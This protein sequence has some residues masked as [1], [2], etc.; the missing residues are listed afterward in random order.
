MVEPPKSY[1]ER[2]FLLM[3]FFFGLTLGI[4]IALGVTLMYVREAGLGKQAKQTAEVLKLIKENYVEEVNLDS[5][6]K[7][8]LQNLLSQLDPHSS[9]IPAEEV[10]LAQSQLETDFEGIGIEYEWLNDTLFVNYPLP[11]SPAE[12]AGIRAGDKILAIDNEPVTY[13]NGENVV[14][15]FQ[16]L[17]GKRGTRVKLKILRNWQILEKSVERDKIVSKSVEGYLADSKI[18]YIRI[19]RF[20]E[21]TDQE[22]SEILESFVQK[23][24]IQALIIDLRENGGGYMDRANRIADELL[25][26]GLLIVSTK[27][28]QK[29]YHQEYKAT[30]GGIFEKG[31]VCVL[32][33][34]G[35]ASASEILAGALQDN[36]RAT[37]IGRKSYG[38]G[39]VQVPFSLSDGSELRLTVSKYYTPSGRCIQRPYHNG[40]KY[41]KSLEERYKTGFLLQDTTIDRKEVFQTRKGKIVYGGGGIV[42][43]IIIPWDSTKYEE[44][45][46]DFLQKTTLKTWLAEYAHQNLKNLQEKGFKDFLQN[47]QIPENMLS[48]AF[49]K[50]NFNEKEKKYIIKQLKAFVAKIIWGKAAYYQVL[51]YE[52]DFLEKAVKI[53]KENSQ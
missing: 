40:K 16:K 23:D 8:N 21:K 24:S 15:I 1:S 42:P 14:D 12:K 33:D 32:L 7:T 52:D 20:A 48:K 26:A 41:S 44:K 22:F 9:Y 13:N 51:N 25:E 53:L 47:W 6:N 34:E 27:G 10:A 35:S 19:L 30:A 43:D 50:W 31:Q 49:V 5:L 3:P 38:K 17:R 39:L 29:R 28:K 46:K 36:D 45:I 2:I 4:G 11:Q 37:L 18:A